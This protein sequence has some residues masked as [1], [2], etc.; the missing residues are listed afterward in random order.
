MTV[1]RGGDGDWRSSDGWLGGWTSSTRGHRS[2]D[3]PFF[4]LRPPPEVAT[5]VAPSTAA[6]VVVVVVVV[7]GVVVVA[8]IGRYSEEVGCVYCALSLCVCVCVCV[9]A[10][11]VG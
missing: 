7:V 3:P 8:R 6:V 1:G 4:T 10:R 9:C 11:A 5:P 2:R